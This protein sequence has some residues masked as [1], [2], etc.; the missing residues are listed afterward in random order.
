[1]LQ[2]IHN[3]AH[4]FNSVKCLCGMGV[5][6]MLA[7]IALMIVSFVGVFGEE[8]WYLGIVFMFL[9]IVVICAL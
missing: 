8:N 4:N 9:I 6:L 7:S 5:V 3:A 2:R 1:M